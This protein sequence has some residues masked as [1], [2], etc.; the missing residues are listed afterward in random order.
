[1]VLNI[2]ARDKFGTAPAAIFLDFDNT[3]YAYQPCHEAALA[4]VRAKS[5]NL[6]AI[7]PTDFDVLFGRARQDVKARTRGTAASHNRLLYFQ[8]LIELAGLKTQALAALD[9][10]QTYWRS[11]L[12]VARLFDG[13]LD[14]LDDVRAIGKPVVLVTNLTA[15]I[16]FRKIIHFGLDRYLD[17]IVTSEEAGAEKPAAAPFELALAK[18]GADVSAIWF[19]GAGGADDMAARTTLRGVVT[20]QKLHSGVQRCEPPADA[21]FDEFDDLRRLLGTLRAP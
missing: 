5:A 17:Y 2:H 12:T 7:P 10:E 19:I 3:L 18:V 6:L 9:L 16:Q 8:R 1:M 11:F 13:V 21:V 14:F 4:Q 15:Q 20:L